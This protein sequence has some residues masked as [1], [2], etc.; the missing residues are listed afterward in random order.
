MRLFRSVAVYVLTGAYAAAMAG[1]AA[2]QA[3]EIRFARQFSMGYLQ[4]NLMEHHRLLEKPPASRSGGPW[5]RRT[6]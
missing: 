2:A 3:P 6:P 1:P 4:F 5:Y